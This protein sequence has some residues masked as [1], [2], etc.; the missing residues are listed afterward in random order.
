[1]VGSE[2]AA[3]VAGAKRSKAVLQR[4]LDTI[5]ESAAREYTQQTRNPYFRTRPEELY[6]VLVRI[7]GGVHV[8][9]MKVEPLG[10]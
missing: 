9:M 2:S 5:A 4:K 1:M 10:K 7:I 8:L 6:E 3:K